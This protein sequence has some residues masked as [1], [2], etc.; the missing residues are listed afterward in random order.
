MWNTLLDFVFPKRSLMGR[1]GEWITEAER[2]RLQSFPVVLSTSALRARKIPYLDRVVAGGTYG[3]SPVLRAAIH[4]FKYGGRR[5]LAEDL[6][7]LILAVA[8]PVVASDT[9][10]CPVPLHFLRRFERGFNQAELIARIIARDRGV[11]IEKLLWRRKPTGHQA[12]RK[13]EDRF[14]PVADAFRFCGG[15]VP[16]HVILIDDLMTTG[17][18][19]SACAKALK[20]AGVKRVEAWV[21][22][23]G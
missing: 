6:A 20:R 23:C 15:R 16:Q 18:T 14:A 12:R 3:E 9:A 10:L 17:A 11:S 7:Q 2:R 8:P 13:R 4:R 21:V 22:A 19:L 5:V 1:E